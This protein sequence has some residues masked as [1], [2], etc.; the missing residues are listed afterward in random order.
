MTITESDAAAITTAPSV[1][2]AA[3]PEGLYELV[4]TGD[5][6]T[7]GRLYVLASVLFL[8]GAGVFGVLSGAEKLDTTSIDL[9][10][11]VTSAWQTFAAYRLGLVFCG[12]LPL[13]I[14]LATAV[15]PLQ[16]GSPAIAFP[17]AA[18]AAFWVWLLGVGLLIGGF[19]ADGG[20][21]EAPGLTGGTHKDGV[22][23]TLLAIGVLVVALLL[24]AVCI[25]TTVISL[26]A[27]GLSLRRVPVFSWSMLVASSVWFLTFPVLLGRLLLA[28]VDYTHAQTLY[29]AENA[30][31]NQFRWSFGQPMVYA[32]AIPALGIV[33]EIIPVAARLRQRFYDVVLGAIALF[34]LLSVGAFASAPNVQ[35][36]FVFL[37][38]GYAI[39]LP[40]L[41]IFGA[42]ADTLRLGKP[43]GSGPLGALALGLLGALVLLGGVVAG[44]LYVFVPLDLR[45]TSAVDGQMALV[46]LASAT[47]GF[48]GVVYWSSKLTGR[49]VPEGL[50]RLAVLPLAGGALLVGVGDFVAGFYDQPAG[51]VTTAVRDG[52]KTMNVV[53]LVGYGVF[54]L[55]ALLAFGALLRTF[56]PSGSFAPADPWHGHTLEWASSSPPPVGNFRGP[57]PVV[58]SERPLL[59][60]AENGGAV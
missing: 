21:G 47:V 28:Y 56:V 18:A 52:A 39:A 53:G 46:L 2:T 5:H 59:D 19:A 17:R 43:A 36:K 57:L 11:G 51:F 25:A 54:A 14:G 12:V 24:A 41:M 9:F 30:L 26:R 50:A 44:V 16:V 34:G 42:W 20:L 32:Y 7:L 45:N 37:A 35:D 60:V 1:T 15:V 55:G 23:L 33:S 58:R 4:T 31:Y 38:V 6:T 40:T 8:L 3:Q 27:P 48:A 13:F 49:A 10:G 22:S 29:G